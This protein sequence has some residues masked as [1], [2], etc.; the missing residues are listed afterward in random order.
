MN[1]RYKMTVV[2]E[3][4][5]VGELTS[6]IECPSTIASPFLNYHKFVIDPLWA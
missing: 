4:Y 6:P 2:S 5:F 3:N 1:W